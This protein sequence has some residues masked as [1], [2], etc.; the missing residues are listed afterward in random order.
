MCDNCSAVVGELNRQTYRLR[1]MLALERNGW[2]TS[3]LTIRALQMIAEKFKDK[4]TAFDT[5]LAVSVNP[6]VNGL[7]KRHENQTH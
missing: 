3:N 5:A 7:E 6:E 4:V 2:D 1:V